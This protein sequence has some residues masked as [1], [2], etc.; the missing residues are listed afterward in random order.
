MSRPVSPP[1]TN[2]RL[3][4]GVI[5]AGYLG[6]YHAEKY[7]AMDAAKL[8]GVVDIDAPRA[9]E[10]ASSCGTQAFTDYR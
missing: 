8:V 6:R 3:R 7:S 1:R 9:A 4:V 2:R 5:G 10:I